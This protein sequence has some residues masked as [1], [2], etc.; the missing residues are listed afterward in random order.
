MLRILVIS[1]LL[2]ITATAAAEAP[3]SKRAPQAPSFQ[4]IELEHEYWSEGVGFSDLDRDGHADVVYGPHWYRGPTFEK[5]HEL[6]PPVAPTKRGPE[7][8]TIYALDN[9][10]SFPWDFDG[11]GW[12]DVLTIGL[13][14]TPAYW[15]RNPQGKP[16][17]WKRSLVLPQVKNESPTFADI[18][19]DRKP[20]LIC[21]HGSEVGYAT[22]DPAAADKPWTFHPISKLGQ[23]APYTH[24]LGV[25]DVDGDGRTDILAKDGWWQQPP[26]L[27]GDPPWPFQPFLFAPRGAK[28]GAQMLVVDVDGDGRN[29]VITSIDAHGWG[30]SWF[31]QVRDASGMSFRENEILPKTAPAPGRRPRVQFSQLHALSVADVDGDG[32]PDIVTGKC[33]RAHGLV[34]DEGRRDPPVL[35]WFRQTRAG[36]TV[37]FVPHLIDAD[38]G[39]GRQVVTGDVDGDGRVDV[40]VGS[41]KGSS[42]FLQR[43]PSKPAV[44]PV[45]GR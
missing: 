39:V 28:G 22:P 10:L 1:T 11:D 32:L 8:R 25:G 41:R 35:Y 42:V 38:S 12:T 14:N 4:R 18:T 40:V 16:E 19:G 3:K 23:Y 17:H 45:A 21:G 9:F 2:G 30:L 6:Y 20:E 43:P 27:T 24:G 31:K 29:D 34:G 26:S 13:A 37:R 44:A 15:Y 33:Y 5:R 36:S 7:D